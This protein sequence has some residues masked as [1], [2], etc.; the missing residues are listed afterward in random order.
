MSYQNM[1]G[2]NRLKY[3]R[4]INADVSD[5][6]A[7]SWEIIDAQTIKF[8]LREGVYWHDAPPVNGREL[9]AD[10]IAY[11][12]ERHSNSTRDTNYRPEGLDRQY[13]EV[14]D[15]YNF[16]LHWFE[17]YSLLFH[18]PS[19]RAAIMAREVVEEYGSA[20][21]PDHQIG[22]GPFQV[23]DIVSAASATLVRNPNY[24]MY[25]PLNP[26]NKLPYADELKVLVITEPGTRKAAFRTG[27]VD[28]LSALGIDSAEE[29]WETAPWAESRG[30]PTAM[31]VPL[32]MNVQRE[33]FTDIRVRRA[34][35]MAVDQPAIIRD[36]YKGYGI[37]DY[38]PL[39]PSAGDAF[40]PLEEMPEDIRKQYEYHP[41]EAKALLAEAGYPNGIEFH[42]LTTTGARA[43]WAAVLAGQM[44]AAGITA[45]I[46]TVENFL[47]IAFSYDYDT[48][49]MG[50]GNL[51]PIDVFGWAHDGLESIWNQPNVDDPIARANWDI[52]NNMS[53][54]VEMAQFLKEEML[55]EMALALEVP[56]PGYMVFHFW[57]PWIKNYH[58]EYALGPEMQWSIGM[59]RYWWIDEDLKT[60]LGF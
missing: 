15:K 8:K 40:T 31:V 24:W 51:M 48:I 54:P 19:T 46:R 47:D 12:F 50:W 42:I 25:D 10:D 29:M 27:K 11:S 6:L 33:P 30:V 5:A 44:A 45:N 55:R 13:I 16:I 59:S 28:V 60:E 35:T 26:E 41:D 2:A 56:V 3:R 23:V 20:N 52:Y 36:L 57:Q 7:E 53:D 58:G 38:W 17:P 37:I 39:Q 9:T 21:D 14:I 43:D 32:F 1:N 22:T 4:G 34:V 18:D 49:L